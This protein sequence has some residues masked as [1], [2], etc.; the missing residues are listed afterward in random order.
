M[1]REEWLALAE[2]CETADGPNEDL[3]YDFAR[4]LHSEW[5]DFWTEYGDITDSVDA[6]NALIEREL[7]GTAIGSFK[8]NSGDL[9]AYAQISLSHD[10]SLCLTGGKTEALARCAAF[11]RAMAEKSG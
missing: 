10:Q 11:C 9:A 1:T 7:P 8:V 2:R 3:T 4:A 6:I 5:V